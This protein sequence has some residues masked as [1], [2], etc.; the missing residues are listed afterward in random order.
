MMKLSPPA[1]WLKLI[2]PGTSSNI[3]G[4]GVKAAIDDLGPP[5]DPDAELTNESA[6][7]PHVR[8]YLRDRSPLSSTLPS[9]R[10][11]RH[12]TS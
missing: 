8:A 4:L 5:L 10:R 6:T 9:S 12:A 11:A 1:V 3:D 7:E 2:T